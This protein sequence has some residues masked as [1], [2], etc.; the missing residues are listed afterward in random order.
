MA[1]RHLRVV[2]AQLKP[3]L[4]PR[5]ARRWTSGRSASSS[6]PWSWGGRPLR[7]P[8]SK[9]PIGGSRPTPTSS[10]QTSPCPPRHAPSSS[11]SS[12]STPASGDARV[13]RGGSHA[14]TGASCASSG[15]HSLLQ[16]RPG[17]QQSHRLYL[18]PSISTL[19]V[20][21][22][23]SQAHA[24]RHRQLA[25]DAKVPAPRPARPQ[26]GG[27][28]GRVLLLRHHRLLPLPL[29][30]R[31]PPSLHL[32]VVVRPRPARHPP[33]APRPVPRLQGPAPRR[34][35]RRSGAFRRRPPHL[36]AFLRPVCL[37][38]GQR[39]DPPD[40]RG[41]R[42]GGRHGVLEAPGGRP[43]AGGTRADAREPR[44]RGWVLRGTGG[45]RPRARRGEGRCGGDGPAPPALR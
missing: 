9:R 12:P 33:G 40:H 5:L 32:I 28:P 2:V 45:V 3:H 42:W 25:L 39:V 15:P 6:T 18:I 23:P 19:P 34:H 13:T 31:G 24:E 4:S 7:Q 17:A 43:A 44:R 20:S 11:P 14:H 36:R 10:P 38:G 1:R 35:P 26:V 30:G 21:L 41:G 16:T 27:A 37:A 29:P 8:T 22:L